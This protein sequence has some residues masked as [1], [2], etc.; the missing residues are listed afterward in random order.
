M[1]LF[2]TCRELPDEADNNYYLYCAL[3]VPT[4]IAP[5]RHAGEADGLIILILQA[6]PPKL[7]EVPRLAQG[8]LTCRAE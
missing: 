2:E 7:K 5:P 3:K 6:R 1:S 4:L 8:C